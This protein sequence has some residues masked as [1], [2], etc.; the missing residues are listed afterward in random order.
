MELAFL[1]ILALKCRGELVI[2]LALCVCVCVCLCGRYF[3]F[4]LALSY[5][6]QNSNVGQRKIGIENIPGFA[7]FNQN[8]NLFET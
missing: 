8:F 7:Q 1:S 4:P 5:K 6:R 3:C 2:G